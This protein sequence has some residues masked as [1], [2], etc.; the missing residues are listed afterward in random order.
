MYVSEQSQVYF[1][2]VCLFLIFRWTARLMA[3]MAELTGSLQLT[4]SI[5]AV[6]LLYTDRWQHYCGT[7]IRQIGCIRLRCWMRSGSLAHFALIELI[8]QYFAGCFVHNGALQDV[9]AH[10]ALIGGAE[11]SI[12]YRYTV[13]I[14]PQLLWSLDSAVNHSIQV[15]GKLAGVAHRRSLSEDVKADWLHS[16]CK[17][18]PLSMCPN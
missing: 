14:K 2:I 10:A 6:C 4:L 13:K 12:S 5:L 3:A 7:R 11:W 15:W 17:C 8:C 18:S 1:I 16:K 9:R